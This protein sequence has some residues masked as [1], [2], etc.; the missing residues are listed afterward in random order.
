MSIQ[1]IAALF[2]VQT[3]L[4]I[5]PFANIARRFEAIGFSQGLDTRTNYLEIDGKPKRFAAFRCAGENHR[6][7]L[8][9]RTQYRQ[10]DRIEI[11]LGDG[12]RKNNFFPPQ[13]RIEQE[14]RDQA[15]ASPDS[16]YR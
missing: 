13:G 5:A 7:L 3:H 2:G 6:G 1:N 9:A 15:I 14:P 4:T 11:S 12:V 8:Q 16:E 10:N